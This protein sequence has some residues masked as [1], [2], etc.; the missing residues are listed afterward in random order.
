MQTARS[1]SHWAICLSACWDTP[2]PGCG[3][4]D[5]QARPLNFPP[6]V[7]VWRPPCCKACWDTTCNACWD[8]TPPVCVQ[9]SWHTLLKI[10]PCPKLRLLAVIIYL[11]STQVKNEHHPGS[12][13]SSHTKYINVDVYG[14]RVRLGPGISV[15]IGKLV[16]TDIKSVVRTFSLTLIWFQKRRTYPEIGY[17]NF[18]CAS[19]N[20][21]QQLGFKMRMRW[22]FPIVLPLTYLYCA[23]LDMESFNINFNID[24]IKYF[25]ANDAHKH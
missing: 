11:I 21:K 4:G 8:T 16:G 3:P 13:G 18:K 7:W 6:W 10:L 22:D 2:L 23:F 17:A 20:F 5:S 1:S 14:H 25:K 24:I 19:W 12:K 9:N 15:K